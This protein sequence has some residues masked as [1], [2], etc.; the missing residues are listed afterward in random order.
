[1]YAYTVYSTGVLLMYL[2]T[3]F[4]IRP[5]PI[6]V[7]LN[8]PLYGCSTGNHYRRTSLPMISLPMSLS[9]RKL[10]IYKFHIILYEINSQFWPFLCSLFANRQ[11]WALCWCIFIW[12]HCS[13][14]LHG[15]I[16]RSVIIAIITITVAHQGAA[17]HIHCLCLHHGTKMHKNPSL[18]E[19][20]SRDSLRLLTSSVQCAARVL[21]ILMGQVNSAFMLLA[22]CDGNVDGLS[23]NRH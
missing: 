13:V 11:Q 20:I 19:V 18:L 8:A 6:K 9:A 17:L 10:S 22:T 7:A 15:Y 4:A 5:A 12:C 23:S 1:M 3:V 21:C 14:R 2:F 16:V